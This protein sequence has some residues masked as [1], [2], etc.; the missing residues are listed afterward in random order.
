MIDSLFLYIRKFSEKI[1]KH[2]FLLFAVLY[3][4]LTLVY[5]SRYDFNPTSM[6]NFGKEFAVQNREL[7]PER[8]VVQKGEEGDLGAGYDGQIFYFYSRSINQQSGWPK[9]FD[10]SYRAPRIGYPLLGA[11][12]GVLGKQGTLF[13]MY[14]FN[15]VLFFISCMLLVKML[16]PKNAWLAVFYLLSPFSLGSYMVLV[17]DSVMVSLVIIAYWFFLNN[18]YLYFSLLAGLAILTKEPALFF[19]FPLGLKTLADRDYKKSLVVLSALVYPF[20]WQLYLKINFPNWSP[21]RLMDFILPLEGIAVYLH[22]LIHSFAANSWKEV[23]RE[24]SRFP[25]FLLFLTGVYAMLDGNLKKGYVFRITLF[26]GFFMIGTAG[27]YHFWSV[28]EN[29]SRMFTITVPA[30][31]LLANEELTTSLK[32]YFLL[33]LGILGLYLLKILLITR[34]H[35]F[36]IF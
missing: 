25:L 7:M 22:G 12:F 3:I 1:Q 14:F 20:F 21:V 36:E 29:I 15:L 11:V 34:A 13:G 35:A 27:H 18:K 32:T 8:A 19:L 24:F 9:G 4:P 26:F 30:A 31:I 2:K 6:L 28:Y 10:D 5:W 16:Q 23:A 33:T 17:S